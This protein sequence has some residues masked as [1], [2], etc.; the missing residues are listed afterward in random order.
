MDDN[1]AYINGDNNPTGFTNN[2]LESRRNTH[3]FDQNYSDFNVSDERCAGGRAPMYRDIVKT[4]V[5]PG[6]V[7]DRFF[8]HKNMQHLKKVICSTVDKNSGGK[9]RPSPESQSDNDLLLVMRAIYLEHAR[10]L[11]EKIK[12]QVKELNHQVTLNLVPRVISNAQQHLTYIRDHSQQPFY[13]DRPSCVSSAGTRSNAS[14]TTR[15]I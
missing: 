12:E 4:I 13:M 1:Y 3:L 11:P 8:S 14:V 2:W 15:F 9:Y 7:S 5:E 10:H 6:P